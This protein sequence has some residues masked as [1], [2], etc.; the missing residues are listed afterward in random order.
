MVN[1]LQ[2][3]KVL[4]S[5]PDPGSQSGSTKTP[6][7]WVAKSGI[8][9]LRG[10]ELSLCYIKPS[11]F[12]GFLT[13]LCLRC[14]QMTS[15]F[16]TLFVKSQS[17]ALAGDTQRGAHGEQ[18]FEKLHLGVGAPVGRD[19]QNIPAA[20]GAGWSTRFILHRCQQSIYI[21]PYLQGHKRV[22]GFPCF[23]PDG[24]WIFSCDFLGRRRAEYL[25]VQTSCID[26]TGKRCIRKEIIVYSFGIFDT[27]LLCGLASWVFVF[28]VWIV[29]S[30][31]KTHCQQPQA[32]MD[33]LYQSSLCI[34]LAGSLPVPLRA[35]VTSVSVQPL[36]REREGLSHLCCPCC[37][38]RLCL[39]GCLEHLGASWVT[40]V[41]PLQSPEIY[42]AV[43]YMLHIY[44]LIKCKYNINR[45]LF[46]G[47]WGLAE[48]CWEIRIVS[49]QDLSPRVWK[50]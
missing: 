17:P 39:L 46:H 11:G 28:S 21:L 9:L 49:L 36:V 1:V 45:C 43:C 18:P 3:E 37:L 47:H 29:L 16:G 31:L 42:T 5:W 30:K 10:C 41:W 23:L 14:P 38:K 44:T 15:T 12:G 20:A 34:Q 48:I 24:G 4:V 40:S 13:S 2:T 35:E 27:E 25:T 22:V 50:W 8:R 26:W 32:L 19:T 6:A 33:Y 7:C